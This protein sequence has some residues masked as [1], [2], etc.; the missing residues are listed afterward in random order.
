VIAFIACTNDET[1][2]FVTDCTEDVSNDAGCESGTPFT[3]SGASLPI[4]TDPTLACGSASSGANDTK[5]FCCIS[6]SAASST[7]AVD[8][9]VSCDVGAI[10]YSCTGSDSPFKSDPSLECTSSLTAN[11]S[12]YCC[13]RESGAADF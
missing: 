3:C 10:G 5:T 11:G 9:T 7:C 13:L 4:D 6:S 8:S 12:D 1:Y 2:T